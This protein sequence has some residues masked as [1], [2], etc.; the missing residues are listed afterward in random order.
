MWD[1]AFLPDRG[2]EED[3]ILIRMIHEDKLV[4]EELASF[5]IPEMTVK[6]F[7]ELISK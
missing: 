5:Q 4:R 2:F 6:E 7:N 3:T 1:C